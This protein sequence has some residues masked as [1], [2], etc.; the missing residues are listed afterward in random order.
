MN[1]V[2]DAIN[3]LF[4][5]VVFIVELYARKPIDELYATGELE[6]VLVRIYGEDSARIIMGVIKKRVETSG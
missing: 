1:S 5:G 4:P 2:K 6:H 3:S